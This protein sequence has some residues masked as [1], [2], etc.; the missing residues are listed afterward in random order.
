VALVIANS[1]IWKAL[2]KLTSFFLKCHASIGNCFA[3][4]VKEWLQNLFHLPIRN[5][6]ISELAIEGMAILKLICRELLN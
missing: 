2:A 6:Q 1:D 4:C 5:C 3:R